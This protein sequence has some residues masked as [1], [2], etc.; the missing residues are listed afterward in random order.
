M[1][2][3]KKPKRDLRGKL[4]AGVCPGK[5]AVMQVVYYK[6]IIALQGRPGK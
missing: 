6:I 3:R 2:D 1:V 4:P 5:R